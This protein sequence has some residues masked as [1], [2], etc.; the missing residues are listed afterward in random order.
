MA[1]SERETLE[2]F[3]MSFAYG[4]RNDLLFK[5]LALQDGI[6]DQDAGEFFRGLL[7]NLGNS[8]DTGDYDEVLQYCYQWQADRYRPKEDAEHRFEYDTTPWAPLKKPL[9]ES[10]LVMISAGGLF[11]EG[12]DPMGPD[13]PT[14]EEAIPRIGEF[15]KL[16]PV[17]SAIPREVQRESI[18]VRHPGY[19]IRG[20][21]RDYN[22]IFPLDR[23]KELQADGVIGELTEEHYSFIGA[24]AQ[25]RLLKREG[26]EWAEQF[27]AKEVDAALLVAA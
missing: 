2:Q 4:S 18:R 22:A 23:L 7:E 19:D 27:R 13:G 26:P 24:T 10:Q 17:L 12:D 25:M 5:F 11:L 21:V 1:E 16:P 20:T 3:R 9:S 6:T 14:Q 8:F 15:Q